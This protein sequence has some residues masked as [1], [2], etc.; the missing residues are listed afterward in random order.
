MFPRDMVCL[1]NI[2]V[3]TLHKGDA[4][5]NN[6][7]NNNNNNSASNC[8]PPPPRFF[9]LSLIISLS[10]RKFVLNGVIDDSKKV[11]NNDSTKFKHDIEVCF[12]CPA[13][14]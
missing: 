9:S 11:E 5:D 14:L 10:V 2:S 4:K 3:D 8:I 12:V 7:N 6:N 1:R 13:A